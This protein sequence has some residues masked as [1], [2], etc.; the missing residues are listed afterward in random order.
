MNAIETLA[1]EVAASV[2]GCRSRVFSTCD[3]GSMTA[4]VIGWGPSLHRFGMR[5]NVPAEA[6]T[7]TA[8]AAVLEPFL[9]LQRRRREN[10]MA[11]G[12]GGDHPVKTDE[13]LHMVVDRV[14]A[15]NPLLGS[16][17][18]GHIRSWGLAM[19][20]GSDVIASRPGTTIADPGALS[21][22]D[23]LDDPRPRLLEVEYVG[24]YGFDGMSLRLPMID[25]PETAMISMPGRRIGDMMSGLPWTD[26]EDRIATGVESL[27]G[28]L[29]VST[30]P[31][32]VG[33]PAQ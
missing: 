18:V 14:T 27:M 10:A 3:D 6:R 26:L 2:P 32:W 9:A 31:L 21:G 5:W 16:A 11:I 1:C 4:H 30:A 17:A 25:L 8:I 12:L 33:A 7:Q 15:R 20:D 22:D 24:Q 19:R 13:I 28:H 23:D 29:H